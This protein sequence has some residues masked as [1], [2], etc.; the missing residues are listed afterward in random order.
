LER[1]GFDFVKDVEYP[2][3]LSNFT[4]E[5]I[6]RGYFAKMEEPPYAF[7]FNSGLHDLSI[8]AVPGF[9]TAAMYESNLA[10]LVALVKETLGVRG[11]KLLWVS[12]SAVYAP[13][14]PVEWRNLTSNVR[15]RE[16]N[17]V[18][19]RVMKKH[20]IPELDVYGV[21]TLPFILELSNDGVH[22]G[23]KRDFYYKYAAVA[24]VKHVCDRSI[25]SEPNS[26]D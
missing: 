18:A 25:S 22:M 16:F 7:V 3:A 9:S 20:R 2:T 6:L 24:M 10:W 4:Q 26:G 12:T 13:A 17:A 8:P 5:S 21:T 19:K 14:Q 15:V 1:I 11:T 23:K